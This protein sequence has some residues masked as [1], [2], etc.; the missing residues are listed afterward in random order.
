MY[1][2]GT[3]KLVGILRDYMENIGIRNLGEVS[4][5]KKRIE[6]Q[7]NIK[8]REEV[9]ARSTLSLYEGFKEKIAQESIY[10]N[11]FESCLLFR[12]RSNTLDLR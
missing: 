5:L 12:A 1:S 7:D 6:L 4:E 3:D 2:K 10:D 9:R 11:T 8:W